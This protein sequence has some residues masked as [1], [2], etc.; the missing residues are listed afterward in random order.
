MPQKKLISIVTPCYNEE[1]N[2]IDHFNKVSKIIKPLQGKYAFEFIYTDNCSKDK[3]FKILKQLGK[4]HK[5]LK[6][7]RFSR[8]IGANRSIFFGLS[9]AKS[10]A[11][12]LLQADLQDPPQL[13]P[14]F[15]LWWERGYDVIYGKIIKRNELFLMQQIRKAYY[16]IISTISDIDIPQ[17]AGEFRLMS[18]RVLDALSQYEEDDVYL[19][20]IIAHIGFKQKAIPYIRDKRVKGHSSVNFFSLIAYGINGLLSTTVAPIRLTLIIGT[21]FALV[22]LFLTVIIIILKLIYPDKSPQGFTLLGAIITLFAG[23][24]M[25]SIGI[26]GEYVRKIYIQILRRPKGFIEEKI[27][28]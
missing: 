14:D 13:I 26:I 24:Q 1:E 25:F 28:I 11:A 9:Q 4:N 10:D 23:V 21:T 27:N 12:I 15:I 8:N 19:R 18:R 22:G 3:T 6:A 16:K 17:N 5:N 20:G 7:I 2:I